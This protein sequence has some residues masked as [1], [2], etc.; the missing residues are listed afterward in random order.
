MKKVSYT[1]RILHYTNNEADVKFSKYEAIPD[2]KASGF[3]PVSIIV[4]LTVKN[5][6]RA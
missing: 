3:K 4:T 5:E 1:D 2:A 6:E